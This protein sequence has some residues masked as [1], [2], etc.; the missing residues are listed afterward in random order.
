M[1]SR[2]P[3]GVHL[4]LDHLDRIPFH[5]IMKD[6]ERSLIEQAMEKAKGNQSLASRILGLCRAKLI[7]KLKEYQ[8]AETN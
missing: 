8:N 7:Y 4:D 1:S 3:Y 2:T 5:Q 6:V